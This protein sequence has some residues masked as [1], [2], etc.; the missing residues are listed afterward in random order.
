M[1]GRLD[2]LMQ[3]IV[4]LKNEESELNKAS[5]ALKDE[6]ETLELEMMYLLEDLGA[7][8]FESESVP[9]TARRIV[10]QH[11]NIV[12]WENLRKSIMSQD[13]LHIMYSRIN[14]KAYKD[15]IEAGFEV[16]G[17]EIFEE[18]KL[19]ITKKAHR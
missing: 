5:K 13:L 2:D 1:S 18:N 17:V 6:R 9:F 16:N 15:A 10:K 7:K 4:K 14:S 11:V 12:D 8:N 3:R 19:Q